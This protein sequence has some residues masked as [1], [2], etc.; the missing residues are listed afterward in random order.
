MAHLQAE[1]VAARDSSGGGEIAGAE[2]FGFLVGYSKRVD[3]AGYVVCRLDPRAGLQ[4]RILEQA[5]SE[6]GL[7]LG[8]TFVD[9]VV[10]NGTLILY[11]VTE[12]DTTGRWSPVRDAFL[13]YGG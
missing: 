7:D 11:P 9:P 6:G 8:L 10:A 12:F 13:S 5:R 1:G 2:C 3:M 4:R